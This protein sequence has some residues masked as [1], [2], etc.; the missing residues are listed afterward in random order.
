MVK[1]VFRRDIHSYWRL[2]ASKRAQPTNAAGA[3]VTV[4]MHVSVILIGNATSDWLARW[5]ARASNI[6]QA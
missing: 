4:D 6:R 3:S 1:G 2:M 5:M